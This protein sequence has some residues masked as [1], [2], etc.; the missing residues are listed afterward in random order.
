M[1]L[2]SLSV[3]IWQ[4]YLTDIH[5]CFVPFFSLYLSLNLTG[6]FWWEVAWLSSF[7]A[8]SIASTALFFHGCHDKDHLHLVV[9]G[10]F[11]V[12]LSG[13]CLALLLG[14]EIRRCC[15]E[16]GD[17]CGQ[18][19][20]RSYGGLGRIEPWTAIVAF[21]VFRY[22]IG[23]GVRRMF[24]RRAA[25]LK[26]D[27]DAS[28]AM[29]YTK[30]RR[31]QREEKADEYGY[32]GK[33]NKHAVKAR[34]NFEA[35]TGNIVDL[36]NSA[37]GLYPD[38]V[39]QYGE[40]SGELLQAMLGIEIVEGA[41]P[42]TGSMAETR[43]P[44]MAAEAPTKSS[45]DTRQRASDDSIFG[46]VGSNSGSNAAT[47]LSSAVDGATS[48]SVAMPLPSLDKK[49]CNLDPECQGIILAGR[50]GRPVRQRS[51]RPPRGSTN[52]DDFFLNS[53]RSQGP[54][55][56]IRSLTPGSPGQSP[57]RSFS[58][59][60]GG[61]VFVVDKQQDKEEHTGADESMLMFAD[62]NA[63][64][65]RSMRRCERRLPPMLNDWAVVDV[66][67]TKY[68]I[69]YFD[70]TDVDDFGPLPSAGT[71]ATE[72]EALE[73]QHKRDTV[74]QA[75]IATKGGKGL[76]LRDVALG[77]RVVG[78]LELSE[79]TGIK[80][81]RF[82]PLPLKEDEGLP[83]VDLE[84]GCSMHQD[85][86]WQKTK[87]PT[88][89]RA[90]QHRWKHAM[91]DRLKLVSTQG[92][93]YLRFFTDLEEWENNASSR[94]DTIGSELVKNQTLLWTQTIGRLCGTEQLQQKLPHLGDDGSAELLD[95]MEFL[96]REL[97]DADGPSTKTTLHRRLRSRVNLQQLGEM[98][99]IDTAQQQPSGDGGVAL[100]V[101]GA[102]EGAPTPGA[103]LKKRFR[104]KSSAANAVTFNLP[105]DK[106]K[107][108][109]VAMGS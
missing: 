60:A 4:L 98:M 3:I 30:S 62:P 50:I 63:R 35:E 37:I 22:N 55:E 81:E 2:A 82:S 87:T 49:Y 66:V 90:R 42:L 94:V 74:R 75:L 96:S 1:V 78:H 68:E 31:D 38:V 61:P 77:R 108:E 99:R 69:V 56:S 34:A 14:A 10:I 73:L 109:E 45:T 18:F 91:E 72:V 101:N 102:E 89:H 106:G 54:S 32:M 104:R 93:L 7:V 28:T 59:T 51:R 97:D 41:A 103:S 13:L 15:A 100:D 105:E 26:G 71:A 46:N 5:I 47:T 23:R 53:L 86:Y 57:V 24:R 70:A 40:F 19:G 83:E 67:I 8:V 6:S 36:W 27:S 76:R 29:D 9:A 12:L 44:A 107:S 79:I 16:G 95:Y 80:V 58:G 85:E 39:K 17:C 21:R 48:S 43:T 52:S 88:A 25:Q 84:D 64:L 20:A 92:E 33:E 11:D 65:I